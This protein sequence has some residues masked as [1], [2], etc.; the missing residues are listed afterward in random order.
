MGGNLIVRNPMGFAVDDWEVSFLTPHDQFQSWAGNAIVEDAGNG[1]NRVTF[2]PADWN[3]SIPANGEI[4][5]SFNAQGEGMPN[6]GSLTR[7]NFFAPAQASMTMDMGMDMDMDMDMGMDPQMGMNMSAMSSDVITGQVMDAVNP[8][9]S[10]PLELIRN[11]SDYAI[12]RGDASIAL[13]GRSGQALSDATS[14]RWDFLAA[15][16]AFGGGFRVLAE[17]EGDRDGQFRVFRFSEEGELFGRGR[18]ISEEKAISCG[19]EACY[20]VDLNG[21]GELTGF[22]GFPMPGMV[23]ADPGMTV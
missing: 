11:G 6:S 7:S 20:G 23:M 16:D 22:S 13:V 14:D 17:G 18:W 1:L 5:I 9:A 19:L 10:E 2:T 4:S 15:K 12:A 8:M 21:D 3:D